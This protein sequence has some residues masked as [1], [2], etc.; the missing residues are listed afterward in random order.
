MTS[1]LRVAVICGSRSDLPA[2]RGCFDTLDAYTAWMTGAAA[3]TD[4]QFH[5]VVDLEGG[6]AV[7][8]VQSSWAVGWGAA[9][10]AFWDAISLGAIAVG[11]TAWA[12][13]S[14][15]TDPALRPGVA[16]GPIQPPNG[17]TTTG[18]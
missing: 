2:L 5:A 6:K 8:L 13:V 14:M 15:Q 3:G 17:A 10:I 12:R 7:G 1:P 4:P 11:C 18:G 9:V 16:L